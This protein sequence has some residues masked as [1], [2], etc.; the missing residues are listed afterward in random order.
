MTFFEK[1]TS[2]YLEQTLE[3]QCS[4]DEERRISKLQKKLNRNVRR[5]FANKGVIEKRE[6]RG[7]EM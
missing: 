3:K 5:N 6:W 2:M 1:I 7:R 4:R